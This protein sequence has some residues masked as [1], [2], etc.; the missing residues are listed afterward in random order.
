MNGKACFQNQIDI[1][2][3]RGYE[4]YRFYTDNFYVNALD[5]EINGTS[6]ILKQFIYPDFLEAAKV[7]GITYAVPNNHM[8]GEYTYLLADKELATKYEMNLEDLTMFYTA[9][10]DFLGEIKNAKN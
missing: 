10:M 1:F 4:D 6:K 7:D 5:E 2:L 9:Y 8:I 3:V